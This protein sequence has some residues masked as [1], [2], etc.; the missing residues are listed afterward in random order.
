MKEESCLKW[1][2]VKDNFNDFFSTFNWAK[3]LQYFFSFVAVVVDA[4]LM[5]SGVGYCS[6]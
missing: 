5:G 1:Q 6:S 3:V 2:L 4:A